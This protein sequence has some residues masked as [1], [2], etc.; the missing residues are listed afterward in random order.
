MDP[1]RLEGRNHRESILNYID[2]SRVD[3]GIGSSTD[4]NA[5]YTKKKLI[6]FLDK[7]GL[8]TSGNKD[9]LV[10]RLNT[11]RPGTSKKTIDLSKVGG[12]EKTI[13][14]NKVGGKEGDSEFYTFDELKRYSDLYKII[15]RNHMNREELIGSL[16]EYN[17]EQND[18]KLPYSI[19][20]HVNIYDIN[21]KKILN[22]ATE[23]KRLATENETAEI[24]NMNDA[25]DILQSRLFDRINDY[26][27]YSKNPTDVD[28]IIY[29]HDSKLHSFMAD[30][31][32]VWYYFGIFTNDVVNKPSITPENFLKLYKYDKEF[33]KNFR[34]ILESVV[35]DINPKYVGSKILRYV[36]KTIDRNN[37]DQWRNGGSIPLVGR[38]TSPL[39]WNRNEISKAIIDSG[40]VPVID[41]DLN[42]YINNNKVAVIPLNLLEI[43]IDK[44]IYIGL[45]DPKLDT[46]DTRPKKGSYLNTY[47]LG[48]IYYYIA[49]NSQF[50]N[51]CKLNPKIME[52]SIILSKIKK[53]L[54][55]KFGYLE[56]DIKD[57]SPKQICSLYFRDTSMRSK[58]KKE[59]EE[60]YPEI[61]EMIKYQPGSILI[62]PDTLSMFAP[63]ETVKY[64]PPEYQNYYNLC[65]DPKIRKSRIVELAQNLGFEIDQ[66]RYKTKEEICKMIQNYIETIFE[67]KRLL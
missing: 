17:Y 63:E 58:I 10:K 56:S 34:N 29:T 27:I 25:L 1:K 6:S 61:S 54:Q 65:S 42:T 4:Q 22:A 9:V 60:E 7:L 13:D 45:R 59:I 16:L 53:I 57:L 11:M 38:G 46:L 49:K 31:G 35:T 66:V 30:H 51:F 14:W 21:R 43:D 33:I 12:K 8:S 62:Q 15:G 2:W 44:N 24:N 28:H 67:S 26:D 19:P 55:D 47:I 64:I 52:K 5:P 23:L 18:S 32:L 36:S 48:S 3:D 50:E 41:R 40:L 37:F 20:K 39:S